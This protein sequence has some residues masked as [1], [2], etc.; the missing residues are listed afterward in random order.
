MKPVPAPPNETQRLAALHAL[1]IL[2]TPAEERFDRITRLAKQ[3]FDVPIVLISLVDSNRV[4]FKSCQGLTVSEIPR[5]QSFCAYTVCD[6]QAL[7]VSDAVTDNRFAN[8]PLV[9][10]NPNVRFYAGHPLTASEASGI[11]ALSILDDRPRQLDNKGLEALKDLAGLV[12]RELNWVKIN[13]LQQQLANTNQALEREMLEHKQTDERLQHV[14]S[15][16]SDHIYVTEFTKAGQRLNRYL[17]PVEALTG[18]PL[19]RLLDDWNFWPSMIIHPEDRAAA[20]GQAQKFAAGQSSEVEY[21]LIRADDRVIWVRD[22]GRV[23]KDPDSGSILVYGVV[24]DITERKQ[25]EEALRF[26]RDQALAAS[27][28]KSQIL[29]KV[30]HELRTPLTAILGFAEMLEFGIY[31]QLTPEQRLPTSEII[32]STKYLNILVSELL[33]QAQLDTGRLKLNVKTFDPT[34]I[35]QD[36]NQ[37]MKVLA[38]GKGLEL[39]TDV[40]ADAPIEVCGDPDRVRQIAVNLVSNGIKFTQ[41]G[42]VHMRLYRPDAAHWALDVSDTGPGIPVEA[43][44]TIFEAFHQVDGSITRQHKGYGLGLSIVKQLTTLMGGRVKL[45]SKVGHGSTFTVM[46]PLSPNQGDTN[47]G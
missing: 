4:W 23:E 17:S 2:D 10:K 11:G 18:Y 42:K 35:V 27:R 16:I 43:R 29:A 39:T 26:A 31:G 45:K 30:S 13:P 3:I 47:G 20:A 19:Q 36:T 8:H 9:T 22:S 25:V 28:L 12:E 24:S 14:F 46:L 38:Q 7:V 37:K 6:Q 15:S 40:A 44:P 34:A 5:I 21:R 32:D 41:H 33:D 1:K